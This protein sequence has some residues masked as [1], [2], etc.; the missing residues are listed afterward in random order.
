LIE[1]LAQAQQSTGGRSLIAGSAARR[2]FEASV[3]WANLELSRQ[4]G[5]AALLRPDVPRNSEDTPCPAERRHQ[6]AA[7]RSEV[8]TFW[9]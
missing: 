9:S 5:D 2:P 8:R 3:V 6:V 1:R 4:A 7:L